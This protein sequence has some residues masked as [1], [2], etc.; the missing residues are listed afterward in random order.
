MSSF[1]SFF[2]DSVPPLLTIAS[3]IKPPAHGFAKTVASVRQEFAGAEDFEFL[4]KV[5]G[6]A[7]D[8]VFESDFDARVICSPDTGVF[9]GMNQALAAAS[10]EWVLF[11]NAGDWLE[12][13]FADAF[14]AAVA[15]HPQADFLCFDGHTV[16]ATDGRAFVR[17]VPE[18]LEFSSFLSRVPVLHAC[19][20]VRRSVMN[21]YQFNTK[22]DLAADFALLGS[23]IADGR[24]WARVPVIGAAMVSG[25]LSEQ[26][27][28]RARW[29][30]TKA[31]WNHFPSLRQRLSTTYAFLR[32]VTI[33]LIIIYLIRPIPS[34]RRFLI[35]LHHS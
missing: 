4:I 2:P 5:K 1:A 30:A 35:K 8:F 13:G 26:Q 20:I 23:M 17:A 15:A 11:L 28:V 32:Y 9:D 25:G 10:G 21:Q 34:L 16:D 6:E 29:Q 31:L 14:R 22:F 19:L 27:R 24:P 7:C 18:T 33:H 3:V 12:P